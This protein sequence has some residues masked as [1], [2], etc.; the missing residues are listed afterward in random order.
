MQFTIDADSNIKP[1]EATAEGE[2]SFKSA[3]ALATLPIDLA[4]VWNSFAGTPKFQDLKPV[5]K[6]TSRSKGAERIWQAIQRLAPA[7]TENMETVE[8]PKTKSQSKRKAVKKT[9]KA[10]AG[11]P[12][13]QKALLVEMIGRKGG[14]TLTELMK[15][16]GWQAH[17]VR[18]AISTL[19][20]KG[21]VKVRSSK[22]DAGERVYE[23]E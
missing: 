16:T 10:A 13:S 15:A 2:Q 3:A 21:G 5:R 8:M 19:G 17:S 4:A 20:R 7:E 18:G 11:T 6:F 22:N 1:G 14:A 23:G 12:G 9:K